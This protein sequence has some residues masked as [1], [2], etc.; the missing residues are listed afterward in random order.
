MAAHGNISINDGQTTPVSHLF[1]PTVSGLVLPDR[2]LRF[3]WADYSVNG[4]VW[5]GANKLEMDVRMPAA[6]GGRMA[7]AGDS[8]NQLATT[9]KFTLPTLETLSN[10]TSSGI[11]PQPTHAYDTTVWVK[12]VRN[13]RAGQ[14]PV[15]DALAFM[16]NFSQLAVYTDVM[17]NYAPPSS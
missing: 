15:K 6:R 17:L 5:L 16:R 1:T 7:K 2:S 11:N 3:G 4:G 10:N 9:F 12:V 8:S 13:G 14:Q